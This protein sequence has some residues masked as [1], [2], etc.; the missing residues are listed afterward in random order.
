MLRAARGGGTISQQFIE[1][2]AGQDRPWDFTPLDDSGDQDS[3]SI[4]ACGQGITLTGIP[5]RDRRRGLLAVGYLER[6][7]GV[8]V[9]PDDALEAFIEMQACVLAMVD[10]ADRERRRS[11]ALTNRGNRVGGRILENTHGVALIGSDPR[12]RRAVETV[13]RAA[14]SDAN[15]LIR[16]PSGS[17]KEQLALLAHV[18]SHRRD[19]PLVAQNCAALPETLIESEL[20]GADR[21]AFTGADRERAGAFAQAHGDTLFLDEIGDLPLTAQAKI[22]RVIETGEIVR[23]G[24]SRAQVDVRLVAATHRDLET[25]VDEGTFREHLYYRLRVVEVLLP[26]LA[27][28]ADDILTLTEYFLKELRRSDG[29]GIGGVTVNAARC[30]QR[31][32]W[33]GNVREL[34]NVIDRA[35]VL[36]RDGVLDVDDLPQE[37]GCL[38]P[39]SDGTSRAPLD[40]PGLPWAEAR[41]RF[42]ESYFREALERHDGAVQATAR[43]VGIDRRTMS[44]TIARYGLRGSSD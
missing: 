34:R 3:P 42:E 22:L 13:E 38:A 35:V 37:V 12:F 27:E 9:R 41:D 31:Y 29:A 11:V 25:M 18:A 16:G 10:E 43:A 32:A 8:P 23:V 4:L 20:F 1:R 40:L 26:A 15:V 30:L 7:L 17:G 14:E 33:P 24:G 2:T 39:G 21:G 36:D 19:H 28:R 44:T 5:F 6:H